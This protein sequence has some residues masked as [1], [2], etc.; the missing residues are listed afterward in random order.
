M[1]KPKPPADFDENPEWTEEDFARAKPASEV[2]GAKI[3]AAMV[4]KRGRPAGSTSPNRKEQIALRVDADVL[5]AYK[6]SGPGW[7]TRMNE[8]LRRGLER[9]RA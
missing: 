3:A 7:Q 5:A 1:N 4:R 2:H 9:K 6:A 8:A